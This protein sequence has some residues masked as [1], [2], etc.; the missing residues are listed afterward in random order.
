M[1]GSYPLRC[2]AIFLDFPVLGS[3]SP[4]CLRTLL[5]HRH[6]VRQPEQREEPRDIPDRAVVP[7]LA[8]TEQVF[9]RMKWVLDLREHADLGFLQCFQCGPLGA[10]L[11]QFFESDPPG[12]RAASFD[13]RSAQLRTPRYTRVSCAG[14]C[15]LLFAAN[16]ASERM[17][18]L[19][20]E[21]TMWLRDMQIVGH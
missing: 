16:S 21:S 15:V 10:V 14:E 13:I 20:W 1:I 9:D 2:G 12:A 7:R 3:T 17:H 11:R 18:R 5:A 4:V 19:I 8:V 6:Q